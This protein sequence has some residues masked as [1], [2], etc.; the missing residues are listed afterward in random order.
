LTLQSCSKDALLL[1]L[2][3]RVPVPLHVLSPPPWCGGPRFVVALLV[4][5]NPSAS[6]TALLA[7]FNRAVACASCGLVNTRVGRWHLERHYIHSIIRARVKGWH[8]YFP[9]SYSFFAFLFLPSYSFFFFL[10]RLLFHLPSSS[11]PASA[12][13]SSSSSSSSHF[14][15][16]IELLVSRPE[17]TKR[18]RAR[19]CAS[20]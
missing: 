20:E 12:A 8:I 9:T 16:I 7:P 6:V 14:L 5:F 13:S 18:E 17:C 2:S 19:D 4:D 1:L 10:F 3:N 11:T 15:C